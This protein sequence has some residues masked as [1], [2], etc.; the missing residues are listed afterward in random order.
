MISDHPSSSSDILSRSLYSGNY[1]LSSKPQRPTVI[2]ALVPV[3][4]ETESTRP[5]RFDVSAL[6]RT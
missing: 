2:F 3:W 5:L 6:A 1:T 4:V